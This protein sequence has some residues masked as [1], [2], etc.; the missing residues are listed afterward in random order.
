MKPLED[1]YVIH[2]QL[3]GSTNYWEPGRPPGSPNIHQAKKGS[4]QER[5]IVG[6]TLAVALAPKGTGV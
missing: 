4:V 5:E 2:W 3:K 6:A 1:M